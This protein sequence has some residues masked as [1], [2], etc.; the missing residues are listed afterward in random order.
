[1]DDSEFLRFQCPHCQKSLKVRPDFAGRKV[2]CPKSDCGKNLVVPG[3]RPASLAV[4][5]PPKIARRVTPVD[6]FDYE[7]EPEPMPIARKREPQPRAKVSRR[8][9]VPE[10]FEELDDG[11]EESNSKNTTRRPRFKR[12]L[13]WI[14]I[15]SVL[16][17][18]A[19]AA[20]LYFT[21]FRESANAKAILVTERYDT[22]QST[23]SPKNGAVLLV[24]TLQDK[25]SGG[26]DSFDAS[27]SVLDAFKVKVDDQPTSPI[28]LSIT[29]VDKTE[30][31]EL[32]LVMVVDRRPSRI[33]LTTPDGKILAMRVDREQRA[34]SSSTAFSAK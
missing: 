21:G 23:I 34:M 18:L 33:E 14:G 9:E 27:N 15:P 25:M 10:G 28:H 5:S 6:D 12:L 32:I 19:V 3:E 30:N 24:V 13:L 16:F 11:L 22:G 17:V 26:L 4:A 29:F 2:K 20:G 7:F 31:F 8:S 1:M